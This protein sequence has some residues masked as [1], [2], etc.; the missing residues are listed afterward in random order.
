MAAGLPCVASDWKYNLEIIKNEVNGYLYKT[1]NINDLVA[2]LENI[3]D[4]N[5]T[6]L[7]KKKCVDMAR[8][9]LPSEALAPL[10]TRIDNI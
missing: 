8:A 1:R 7:M 2:K 10:F 6:L 4:I 9:Y 3:L 5:K